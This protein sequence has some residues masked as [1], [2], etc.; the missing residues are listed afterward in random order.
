MSFDVSNNQL[1]GFVPSTL[2]VDS[3]NLCIANLSNNQFAG[4]VPSTLGQA[5]NL[6]KLLLDGNQLGGTIP[7]I[8]TSGQLQELVQLHL[9]NNSDL[10]GGIPDTI[11]NLRSGGALDE[12][13]ADCDICLS[14]ISSCCTQCF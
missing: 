6:K 5:S 12:L 4:D 14:S 1:T 2:F 11:C 9:H 13:W 3:W 10:L 7:A 8:T